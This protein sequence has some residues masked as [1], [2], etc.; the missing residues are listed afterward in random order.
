MATFEVPTTRS[1]VDPTV[2]VLLD[3]I[4]GSTK[5]TLSQT[6]T[7]CG[8]YGSPC[9]CMSGRVEMEIT[10]ET[11]GRELGVHGRYLLIG[12]LEA[13]LAALKGPG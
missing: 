8:G 10:P 3:L 13:L 4:E 5:L 2:N 6:C 9:R 11:V 1:L 7:N 12:R